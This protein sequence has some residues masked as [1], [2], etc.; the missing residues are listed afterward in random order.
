MAVVYINPTAAT[1][2]SGASL[3]DPK[4]T[5][6]GLTW[7]AGN[8]YLQV[9][10]TTH[11]GTANPNTSG[12]SGNPITIGV[13][14]AQ[15]GERVYTKGS[16]TIQGAAGEHGVNL[17][18]RSYI[19]IDG[20]RCIADSGSARNGINGLAADALTA[21]FITLRRVVAESP[22]SSTGNGVQLRGAGDVIEDCVFENCQQDGAFLT[23][24]DFAMRRTLVQNVDLAR[25]AGDCVQFTGTHNYGSV[26]LEDVFLYGHTDSPFKQC[27]I[28]GEGSGSFVWRRGVAHGMV[29]GVLLAIPGAIVEGV[30]VWGG[31]QRGFTL[32]G[33]NQKVRS[34]LVFDTPRGVS[35]T[36]AFTGAEIDNATIIASSRGITALDD[37]ATFTARNSFIDAPLAYQG[38]AASTISGV[39]NAFGQACQW[40]KGGTTYASLGEWQAASSTDAASA[41]VDP[42][43]TDAYMPRPGSPLLTQ[44]ADL[45]Y[46]RDIRG[47][48]SR[49]HIGAYGRA[50]MLLQ[51][52]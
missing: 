4:N 44:G 23:V 31:T 3:V 21:H 15:T 48:Q 37:A 40:E 11:V 28:T 16:A 22:V 35:V 26:V 8:E 9:E 38:V 17:G 2:G 36:G 24:S 5:Y 47:F 30:R 42:M 13:C 29:T 27:L 50:T 1:N 18:T 34:C 41:V 33:A 10:G 45:G 51:R 14:A 32:A 19:E 43:L 49:K 52:G 25:T 12:V 20:L 39:S 6:T 46:I 7:T